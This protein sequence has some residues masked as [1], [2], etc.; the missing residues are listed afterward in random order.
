MC[1]VAASLFQGHVMSHACWL[2]VTTAW[3]ITSHVF[4]AWVN[5][6]NILYSPA[7]CFADDYAIASMLHRLH[8][9]TYSGS[10]RGMMLQLG[11]TNSKEAL[12]FQFWHPPVQ[13]L[14]LHWKVQDSYRWGRGVS[15]IDA[16]FILSVDVVEGLKVNRTWQNQWWDLMLPYYEFNFAWNRFGFVGLGVF[17]LCFV[18]WPD[19]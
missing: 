14:I 17:C 13:G 3:P 9:F 1:V 16:A 7:I 8:S 10:A 19:M 2:P 15:K 18:F 5:G 11:T 4:G 6:C 12:P